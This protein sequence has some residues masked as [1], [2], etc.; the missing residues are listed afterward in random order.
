MGTLSVALREERWELAA[1]CLLV[2]LMETIL[3]VPEDA[4][5]GLL[6]ALEGEGDARRE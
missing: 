6:E 3:R 5:P 2:G 4:L 1:H